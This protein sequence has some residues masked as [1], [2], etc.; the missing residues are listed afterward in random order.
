MADPRRKPDPEVNPQKET[1]E[2]QEIHLKWDEK[3][4]GR[5]GLSQGA[6]EELEKTA[7]PEDVD[8]SPGGPA[9]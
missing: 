1:N 4:H 2:G 6:E 9:A 7:E 5:P 3:G 8:E